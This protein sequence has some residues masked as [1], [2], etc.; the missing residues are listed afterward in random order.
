VPIVEGFW[1]AD[2][3][4]G[5]GLTSLPDHHPRKTLRDSDV[6]GRVRYRLVGGGGAGAAAAIEAKDRGASVL[7]LEKNVDAGRD[8][9]SRRDYSIGYDRQGTIERL[10]A[11]EPGLQRLTTS[12]RAFVDGLTEVPDGSRNTVAIS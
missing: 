6:E 4:D 12:S 9:Q 8:T 10:L 11:P 5:D 2:Q 1:K 3:G 7:I